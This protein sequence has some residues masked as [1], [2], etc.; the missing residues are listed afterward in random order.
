MP[1]GALIR[2][3][4]LHGTQ[5]GDVFALSRDDAVEYLSTVETRSVTWK[6]FP[7]VG[8]CFYTNFRH[9]ILK[10]VEDR[11]RGI[12]DMPFSPC[13]QPMFEGAHPNCRDNYLQAVAE[14][15][16]HRDMVLDPVNIFQ[17]TPISTSGSLLSN[18]TPTKPGDYVC[19][20]AEMD[21]IFA[22][23]ACS[24]DI[25]LNEPNGSK[26]T[27]LQIEILNN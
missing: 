10:F 22:L 26:S 12:H 9:P 6:L 1:S 25:G 5:I 27:S 21:V 2:I 14:L 18:V 20:R 8:D 16:V 19:F 11:S 15:G 24:V 4:D 3:T 17:N 23:T 7:R 13:D